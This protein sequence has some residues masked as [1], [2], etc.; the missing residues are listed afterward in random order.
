MC[1]KAWR[2]HEGGLCPGLN[3]SA[4]LRHVQRIV[5]GQSFNATELACLDF[6]VHGILQGKDIKAVTRRPGFASICRKA[7]LMRA[8]IDAL[9][10]LKAAAG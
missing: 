1:R 4:F 7:K 10:S 8:R 2:D 9:K 3:G 5:A 6:I